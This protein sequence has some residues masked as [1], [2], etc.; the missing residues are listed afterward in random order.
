MPGRFTRAI[1]LRRQRALSTLILSVV[2][3]PRK[4]SIS[5]TSCNLVPLPKPERPGNCGLKEKSIW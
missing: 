4:Q 2:L 3:S 1:K 5:M